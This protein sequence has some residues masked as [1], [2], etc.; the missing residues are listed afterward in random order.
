VLSGAISLDTD[1]FNGVTQEWVVFYKINGAGDSYYIARYV[2]SSSS[3]NA[4]VLA[5]N[6]II[7]D[8][9][10]G[11]FI[12]VWVSQDSG[13]DATLVGGITKTRL[14][15]HKITSAQEVANAIVGFSEATEDRPG[16]VKK[17]K[18]Q[19]KTHGTVSSAGT[20]SAITFSNLTIGKTYRVYYTT[21]AYI[22]SPYSSSEY[23]LVTIKHDGSDMS[24][25]LLRADSVSDA[26]YM[27]S[28]TVTRP[29]IATNTTVTFDLTLVGSGNDISNG[30]ATLVELANYEETDEW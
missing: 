22:K 10:A 30:T 8:L 3:D 1:G 15:I 9:N 12:E 5:I 24:Y 27:V 26:H 13:S 17:N 16:L 28:T 2:P 29:F 11:D 6:E 21:G 7:S 20:I 18:Y 19:T 25:V 4:I 23:V 14:G